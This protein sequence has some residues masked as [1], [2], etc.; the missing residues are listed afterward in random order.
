MGKLW[1]RSKTYG[2]GWYPSSWEGWLVLLIFVVLFLVNT[3]TLDTTSQSIPVWFFIRTGILVF[4]LLLVCWIKGE[5]PRWRWG[6]DT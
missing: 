6:K 1:F 5:T 3:I 2:W 4:L